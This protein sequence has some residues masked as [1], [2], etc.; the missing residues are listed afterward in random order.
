MQHK[1]AAYCAKLIFKHCAPCLYLHAPFPIMAKSSIA[2]TL[3]YTLNIRPSLCRASQENKKIA[4][5]AKTVPASVYVHWRDTAHSEF[6]G[7]KISTGNFAIACSA[8]LQFFHLAAIEK[9]PMMLPSKAADSVWHTWLAHDKEGLSN[10]LMTHLGRDIPHVEK[11]NMADPASAMA[12]TWRA[13]HDYHGNDQFAGRLPSIFEADKLT[14]MPH[15]FWYDRNPQDQR[16]GLYHQMDGDGVPD[17]VPQ[18]NDIL[19]WPK[20]YN[21]MTPSRRAQADRQIEDISTA[22]SSQSHDL[23]LA[24]LGIAKGT[25]AAVFLNNEALKTATQEGQSHRRRADSSGYP[26]PTGS[27]C[28]SSCGG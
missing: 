18:D 26:S 20:I 27:D 25:T 6:P 4:D 23:V 16:E 22:P 3:G 10:F 19:S 2:T 1:L 15:G 17:L 14:L 5:M 8:L 12:D 9:S 21:A 28:G 11:N 7:V 13:A 24:S